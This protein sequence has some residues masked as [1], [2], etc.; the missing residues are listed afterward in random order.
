MLVEAQVV[1]DDCTQILKMKRLKV[2]LK[3]KCVGFSDILWWGFQ[4]KSTFTFLSEPKGK[5]HPV[6]M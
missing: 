2:P 6:T 3:V 1:I 5:A 4:T